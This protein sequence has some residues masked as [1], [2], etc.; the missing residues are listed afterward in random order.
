MSL[1]T[2]KQKKELQELANEVLKES[3]LVVEDYEENPSE[4][5]GSMIQ[6][7]QDSPHLKEEE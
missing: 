4:L 7:H 2:K 6:I 1:L 3:K 5:S